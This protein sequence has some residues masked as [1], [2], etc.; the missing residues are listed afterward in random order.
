VPAFPAEL[1]EYLQWNVESASRSD[2]ESNGVS[3][4]IPIPT[5]ANE[6]TIKES[7]CSTATSAKELFAWVQPAR[8]QNPSGKTT[9]SRTHTFFALFST[10]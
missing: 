1:R 7:S 8:G 10:M 4:T 2:P 5:E 6:T 3:Y 9:R